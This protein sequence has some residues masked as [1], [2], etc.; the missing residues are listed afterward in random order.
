MEGKTL[1][2]RRRIYF[3]SFNG[4]V[5]RIAGD[6]C[7]IGKKAILEDRSGQ[8]HANELASAKV[9]FFERHAGEATLFE[10]N[11]LEC[12]V[13]QIAFVERSSSELSPRWRLRKLAEV[14][15]S[16]FLQI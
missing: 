2:E 13:A 4:H 9:Q 15:F 10:C 3:S 5:V 14:L 16:E 12:C 1:L 7:S 6:K 8:V 11:P